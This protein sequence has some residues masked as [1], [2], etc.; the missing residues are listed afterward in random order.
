MQVGQSPTTPGLDALHLAA[1]SH[2]AMIDRPVV[3][4]D[5]RTGIKCWNILTDSQKDSRT[6]ESQTMI[7]PIG[8]FLYTTGS[9]RAPGSELHAG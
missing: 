1:T 7:D 8:P 2:R 3:S 6:D 9:C 5:V 4:D